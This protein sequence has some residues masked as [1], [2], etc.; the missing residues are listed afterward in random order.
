MMYAHGSA[1]AKGDPMLQSRPLAGYSIRSIVFASM[2]GIAF[3][4][5]PAAAADHVSP[6]TRPAAAAGPSTR[7]SVAVAPVSPATRPASQNWHPTSRPVAGD[8][9]TSGIAVWNSWW[10]DARSAGTLIDSRHVLYS[11]HYGVLQGSTVR[12]PSGDSAAVKTIIDL[13]KVDI[14]VGTLDHDLPA[15]NHPLPIIQY[16]GHGWITNQN[17]EIAPVEITYRSTFVSWTV[18]LISGDSG[19]PAIAIGPD[20]KTG[21]VSLAHSPV[22][23]TALWE[24]RDQI[25]AA[26]R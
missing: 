7:P 9:D 26:K 6:T 14:S 12:W 8:P 5:N 15:R 23:G 19:H 22:G 16:S 24:I 13:P 4:G 2:A 17:S 11:T 20:G 25:E 1:L 3:A 10:K 18:P 21:V